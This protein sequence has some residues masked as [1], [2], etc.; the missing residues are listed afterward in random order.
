V[1]V[2]GPAGRSR[3]HAGRVLVTGESVETAGAQ[4]YATL[5]LP[6][7]TRIELDPGSCLSGLA[8]GA[9]K[10]AHLER[11]R[12]YAAVTRQPSGQS[13]VFT[14]SLAAA[15]VLGTRLFLSAEPGATRLEVT[16]GRVRLVRRADGASV[17][18]T[19]DH[20]ALVSAGPALAA[21]PLPALFQDGFDA[22][23]LN[24][25]PRGWLKHQTE[26]ANRSGFA[27]LEERGRPR[28]RFAGCS[29]VL[30][31]T[32][33]HAVLPLADWPSSF[34]V[35]FRMRL[36]GNRSD[37]AGIEIDDGRQDQSFQYD[38]QASAVEMD[39]PRNTATRQA[40]LRLAP[41]VWSE[42]TVSV[43]GTRFRVVVDRKPLLDAD[44]PNYGRVRGASLVTRG[45]DPAQF[46]DVKVV[47]R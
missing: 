8:A 7:G 15:R 37:R 10:A 24:E 27:V 20:Y 42:W 34:A 38:A 28:E 32:T 23:P 47:R 26:P 31:G 18:V 46:D 1:E 45:A 21:R 2:V 25:W 44:I 36:T 13:I 39:W 29:S 11:G 40:P 6:D 12:L 22:S 9:A 43:D 16:E 5:R 14:T 19:A 4:S 35:S 33:Q 41:G 30:G 17:D 3:A